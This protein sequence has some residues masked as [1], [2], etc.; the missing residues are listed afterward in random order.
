ML[1]ASLTE[2]YTYGPEKY[3][4][5]KEFFIDMDDIEVFWLAQMSGWLLYE[6]NEPSEEEWVEYHTYGKESRLFLNA[7]DYL[8]RLLYEGRHPGEEE[9][10]K[11]NQEA[12]KAEEELSKIEW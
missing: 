6:K 11:R 3:A 4:K 2:D 12:M 1:E 8:T 10:E 7:I 5:I 9:I